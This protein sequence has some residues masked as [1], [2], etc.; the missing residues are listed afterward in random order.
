MN[1]SVYEFVGWRLNEPSWLL[2]YAIT[3]CSKTEYSLSFISDIVEVSLICDSI[4]ECYLISEIEI[5]IWIPLDYPN[6]YI[7]L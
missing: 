1:C 7:N 3:D 2:N 6:Y 5:G 4:V